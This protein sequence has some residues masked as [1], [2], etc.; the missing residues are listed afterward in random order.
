MPWMEKNFNGQG[1]RMFRRKGRCL[2]G[3]FQ[4]G[5]GGFSRG[6]G[7]GFRRCFWD[8]QD[9]KEF[10]LRKKAWF[11]ERLSAIKERLASLA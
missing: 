10:L 2:G 1:G 9:Q 5:P 8:S 4:R 6:F 11:E 3:Q 7:A